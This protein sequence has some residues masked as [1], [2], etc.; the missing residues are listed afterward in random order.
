MSPCKGPSGAPP[1]GSTGSHCFSLVMIVMQ[2][3]AAQSHVLGLEAA[4]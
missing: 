3:D 1:P 4:W 2:N